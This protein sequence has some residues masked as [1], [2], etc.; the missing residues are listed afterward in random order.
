VSDELARVH[1]FER[2]ID[3][4]GTETVASPLGVGV[5]TPELPLRQDSNYLLLERAG[6]AGEAIGEADRILGQAGRAHRV[7][8]TF[9]EE[10]ARRLV[11][12]FQALGWQR[13]RHVLMVQR[14][15]PEKRADLSIVREVDESALRPGRTRA[16][17]AQPWGSKEL[18][19]QLLDSKLLI[20]ER[21]Q[22]RFFGVEVDGEIVAWTDLYVAQGVGQVEDVATEPEH[23]GKG[24]ATAV[25]L[26]AVQEAR[27]AGADLVFLVADDEDWPKQLYARL[28]FDPIGRVHKFIRP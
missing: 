5:L 20:A 17:V 10:L 11:P 1:R 18:A 15:K 8:V 22:T 19:Q 21:A 7:I 26:R 12:Q 27:Q 4:A 14:R 24:Y 23:R 28:G 9:D 3:L 6:G 25:V 16:I 2:E 13:N